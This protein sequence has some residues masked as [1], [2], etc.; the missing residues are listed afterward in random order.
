M[1]RGEMGWTDVQPPACN[2]DRE[3][4]RVCTCVTLGCRPGDNCW[5]MSNRPVFE[6]A[7]HAR[8]PDDVVQEVYRTADAQC[9]PLQEDVVGAW[10]TAQSQ[11]RVIDGLMKGSSP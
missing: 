6:G 7:F 2:S 5:C 10:S 11:S 3:D 8:H 4:S 9:R 1:A